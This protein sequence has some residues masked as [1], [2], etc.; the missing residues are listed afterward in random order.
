MRFVIQTWLAC[1]CTVAAAIVMGRVRDA[2]Q[3]LWISQSRTS[4]GMNTTLTYYDP[5]TRARYGLPLTQTPR[6]M[7][8]SPNQ[9]YL[10]YDY[11]FANLQVVDLQ[12]GMIDA[13]R[14]EDASY[15]VEW[16]P[17][18]QQMIATY[19]DTI[20]DLH[21][22]NRETGHS[23]PILAQ[24]NATESSARWSPDGEYIAFQFESRSEIGV[25]LCVMDAHTTKDPYQCLLPPYISVID[26]IWTPDS[27]ALILLG[28]D[29]NRG[30]DLYRVSASGESL[31]QLLELDENT[32]VSDMVITPDGQTLLFS[33]SSNNA[34]QLAIFKLD[35]LSRELTCFVGM[36]Y[37]CTVR[38]PIPYKHALSPDGNRVAFASA[39]RQTFEIYTVNLDGSN[40]RQITH[41]TAIDSFPLWH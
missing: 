18:A 36:L 9:R 26:H 10:A 3:M 12:R 23:T 38:H 27:Q 6:N 35:L 2:D 33:M 25:Q 19:L 7:Q 41:D 40:L 24:P 13:F 5:P 37:A 31:I 17:D 11:E 14:A 20:G 29:T 28:A 39:A 4:S 22:I 15:F 8:V 1:V 34:T 16:S 30:L 32:Q 21:L